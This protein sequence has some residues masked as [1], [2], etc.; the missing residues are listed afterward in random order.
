MRVQCG[1]RR[2]TPL[3]HL[4][5]PSVRKPAAALKLAVGEG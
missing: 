5:T 2:R 1:V 3:A 4:F